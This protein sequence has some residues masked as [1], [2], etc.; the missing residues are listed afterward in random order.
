MK[1]FEPALIVESNLSIAWARAFLHTFD[2]GE[3]ECMTVAIRNFNGDLPDE[4]QEI[5]DALVGQL[6]VTNEHLIQAGKSPIPTVEQT[7]LTIV[8]YGRWLHTNKR[9]IKELSGW[10][11]EKLLPRLRARSSKNSHGTYFE[12]LTAFSGVRTIRGKQEVRTVNQLEFVTDWWKRRAS[13]NLRPRQSALQFACFDPAKDH[14]GSALAG[15]PCLQQVSLT[16]KE[17]GTLE[18]NA[19]YPTQY[20]F[21]RAYGN[22]LGL[23]QLGHVIAHELGVRLTGLTCFVA[24]P[25]FGPESKESLKELATFLRTHLKRLDGSKTSNAS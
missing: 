19:Y 1:T 17:P 10:Y 6:R 13:K 14:T 3:S 4:D 25:E 11:L 18:I 22:Y 21:E 2:G 24:C 23:C 20:I 16:Y 15:F 8:P 9:P 5:A 12:R 7:A